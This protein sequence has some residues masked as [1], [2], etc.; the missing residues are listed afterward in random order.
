M[1]EKEAGV[2]KARKEALDIIEQ[3]IKEEEIKTKEESCISKQFPI[4]K[5]KSVKPKQ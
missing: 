1:S 2:E 5:D 4:S 3:W